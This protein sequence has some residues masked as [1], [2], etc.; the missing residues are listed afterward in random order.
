[1]YQLITFTSKATKPELQTAK[2]WM[3]I[4]EASGHI[5]NIPNHRVEDHI[6]DNSIIVT[7]GKLARIAVHQRLEDKKYNNV[8]HVA[9]P[10]LKYLKKMKE[11]KEK[12][13]QAQQELLAIKELLEANL[14]QPSGFVVK[15]DDL[16]DLDTRHLLLLQKITEEAGQNSCF[17]VTKGGKLIEISIEEVEDSKADTHLTFHELYT[18]RAAMDVL[19]VTEVTL[20]K[21][22]EGNSV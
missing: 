19:G 14:F 13:Q 5:Y 21:C 16:P 1:M 8:K 3:D 11:N 4:T 17:Q 2:K 6:Q 15:E 18:I 7:F 9:L 10:H 20:A 22:D 12:R